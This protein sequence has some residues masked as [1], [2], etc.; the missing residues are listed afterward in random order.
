MYKTVE[1]TWETKIHTN[2]WLG[3]P[4]YKHTTE[5]NTGN[6]S[7]LGRDTIAPQEPTASLK[8]KEA[9][10][11]KMLMLFA[12]YTG[13]HARRSQYLCLLL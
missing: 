5:L 4:L 11:F 3:V 13:P 12:K 1:C 8:M 10:Y 6:Y 2:I 9:D 7:L